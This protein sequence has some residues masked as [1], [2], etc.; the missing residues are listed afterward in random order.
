MEENPLKTFKVKRYALLFG[1]LFVAL[2][3]ASF[4]WRYGFIQ[5][6]VSGASSGSQLAYSL[7]RQGGGK[8]AIVV[9]ADSPTLKRL[10][11]KANYEILVTQNNQSRFT[12]AKTSGFFRTQK[13][14]LGLTSEH[15]RK[16]VGDNPSPCMYYTDRLYSYECGD[17]YGRVNVHVP[18]TATTPTYVSRH[19]VANI[20]GSL[21]GIIRTN[22]GPV[23]LSHPSD[24][25][26]PGEYVAYLFDKNLKPKE[27]LELEELDSQKT[28]AIKAY[29]NGG[30]MIYSSDLDEVVLYDGW[31][32]KGRPLNLKPPEDKSLKAVSLSTNGTTVLLVYSSF[33]AVDITDSELQNKRTK[34][35]VVIYKDQQVETTRLDGDPISS[36]ESC[37]QNQICVLRNG[38]VSIIDPAGQTAEPLYSVEGV[39]SIASF[40]N[41]LL[42]IRN[43]EV[44]SL[45]VGSKSGYIDYAL[46]GL[47]FCGLQKIDD[48]RYVLCVVDKDKKAALLIDRGVADEDSLD[49][50]IQQLRKQP[51]VK[52]ISVYANYVFITPDLGPLVYDSSIDGYGYSPSD[53]QRVN[54]S[55]KLEVE[56]LGISTKAYTVIYTA[57]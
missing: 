12:I 30:F 15:S 56:R 9:S 34:N 40:G 20:E 19:S 44:L 22:A 49:K 33:S 4:I 43:R 31:N 14:A 10:V 29:G 2:L 47:S 35:Q 6:Q 32:A 50:K 3:V 23:G 17:P 41:D 25:E 1:L 27:T 24:V 42:A 55:L 37:G 5:I 28:Y 53:R 7:Q 13:V 36:A 52:D 54:S 38:V 46:N 45:D 16:F 18:A 11:S 26:G 8:A 48:R 21:E 39:D 51:G 57:D